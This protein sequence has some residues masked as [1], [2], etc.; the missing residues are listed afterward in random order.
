MGFAAPPAGDPFVHAGGASP[1]GR[2]DQY[3]ALVAMI[4]GV[5]AACDPV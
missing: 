4:V 2:I 5:M 3:R 1:G